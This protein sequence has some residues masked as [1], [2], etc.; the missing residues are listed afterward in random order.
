MEWG[1]LKGEVPDDP[2]DLTRW[3]IARRGTLSEVR[4]RFHTRGLE[5]HPL[6]TRL[7]KAT[8]RLKYALVT[9]CLDD[10]DFAPFAIQ[11]GKLRGGWLGDAWREPF[12]E[13]A[14][15]EHNM[16]LEE[17]YE[18][19]VIES[20]A[21]SWMTEAAMQIATGTN[22]IYEWGG[23]RVYR[24]LDDERAHFMLGLARAMKQSEKD[25]ES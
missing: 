17:V 7:S 22:R 19:D 13:R 12:Y 18:D 24:D 11:K 3:P 4:Y 9:H 14:A 10:N 20:I 21:E 5:V 16:T 23:G 15:R 1:R 8:P 2:F 6:L 25:D